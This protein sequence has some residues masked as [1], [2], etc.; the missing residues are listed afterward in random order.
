M[1][2]KLSEAFFRHK[3]L[4]L[5]PLILIPG[6]VTP[7][8]VLATPVTYDTAVAV[9][10]DHPTYLDYNDGTSP[11]ITPAQNQANRLTELLHTRTF[12]GDVAKRT[13]MASLVG[14]PTGDA[15]ISDLFSR[16]VT[17]GRSG[18]HVLTVQ[19]QG[20]TPQLAFDLSNAIID[21]YQEKTAADLADQSSTAVAF[22]Q[23]RLQQTQQALSKATQDLHRYLATLAANSDDPSAVTTSATGGLSPA[24]ANDP[25][26]VVLQSAVTSAQTDY[27]N[28]RKAVDQAQFNTS[29]A[30]Q[31]Q[32]VGFQVL[33]PPQMPTFATRPIKKIII[34]P[35]AA[36][37]AGLLLSAV[38]LVIVVVG[39]R[40]ARGE[41]DLDPSLRVLGVVPVL[42]M[43]RTPKRFRGVA[44][45]RAI[46]AVAGAALPAF[47][48]EK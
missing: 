33:D 3:L 17:V 38:V 8:A 32:Q 18:D 28:A 7:V 10:V 41:Y 15:R 21:A 9:W 1:T 47:A 36:L 48:G 5:L 16:A 19:V 31:G 46:G 2:R 30:L 40:S 11:Y 39:D 27:D 26:A 23:D 37:A 4:L 22:Y 34:Y 25:K 14:S 13:S 35:I 43:K 6:I 42:N 45:R 12:Q 24:V 29:A 44:T 20:P